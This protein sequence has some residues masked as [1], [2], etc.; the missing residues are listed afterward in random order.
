MNTRT[1]LRRLLLA[2]K[3]LMSSLAVMFLTLAA[4]GLV[5]RGNSLTPKSPVPTGTYWDAPVKQDPHYVIKIQSSS[6][7]SFSGV[8]YFA[9]QDGKVSTIFRFTASK[10]SGLFQ[11]HSNPSHF[12]LSAKVTD[13]GFDLLNCGSKMQFIEVHT[14]CEFHRVQA[15]A[16]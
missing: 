12:D 2:R 15:S 14:S 8:A 3:T 13:S 9:Y 4:C 6:S 7:S 1:S 11:L 10:Q 16:S 5:V